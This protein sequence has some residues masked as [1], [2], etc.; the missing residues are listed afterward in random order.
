LS[1]FKALFSEGT[2]PGVVVVDCELAL[3]CALQMVFPTTK[4]LLCAWHIEKNILTHVSKKI[5]KVDVQEEF[6]KRWA[7]LISSPTEPIYRQRWD[8]FQN[9]YNMVC[10]AT[11]QYVKDTWLAPFKQQLV[12]A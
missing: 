10:A 6:M 3:I 12:H 11:V 9:T 4:R 1:Q 2:T 7:E 5:E 8:A